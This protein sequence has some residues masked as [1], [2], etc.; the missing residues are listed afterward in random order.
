M[1]LRPASRASGVA[2]F[3]LVELMVGLVIG[4]IAIIVVMQVF[5]LSEGSK[6]T[7]TGGDDAQISGAVALTTLQRDIRQAG[8]GI[9]N[10]AMIGCN[11][12][13]PAPATWTIPAVAPMS[14]NPV[15][16]PAGDANTDTLMVAYGNSGGSTEGDRVITQ[17]VGNNAVYTVATPTSFT[18]GDKIVAVPAIS[19]R[20]SPCTLTIEA[21]AG[22][23]TAPPDVT[24]TT[25][26]AGMT[27]GTLFDLGQQP[28]VRVYAIRNGALTSCDYLANDCSLAASVGNAAVWVPI[29][30]NIVSLR[31]EYGRDTSGPPMDGVADAWDQTSP[32]GTDACGWTRVSAVRISLVARSSQ[33]EKTAVS[34]SAP[35]W[36]GSASA[37]TPIDLSGNAN[38]QFYRYKAFETTVPL[39]NMAWQPVQPSC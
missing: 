38:W 17:P 19:P 22:V 20:P 5:S 35:T 10:F 1:T 13:P 27:D 33:L 39:R 15:G 26:V 12:T 37:V 3:S 31:A 2:G 24:V 29:G 14:I 4:M 36:A 7:T 21:A 18:A 16:I 6:R 11:L 8:Y 30:D 25:G 23:T 32:A 34:T 9:A 28:Q